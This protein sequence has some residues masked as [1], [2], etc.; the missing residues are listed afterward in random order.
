MTGSAKSKTNLQITAV[1][2]SAIFIFAFWLVSPTAQIFGQTPVATP[3]PVARPRPPY[4]PRNRRVPRQTPPTNGGELP[5]EKSFDVDPKVN[6]TLCVLSGDVK[7]NGWDR[8][9]IRALVEDGNEVSFSAREK[10]AQTGRPNLVKI[11]GTGNAPIEAGDCLSGSEIELD[12]PRGATVNLTG[13]ENDISVAS[14]NKAT[15]RNDGGDI[16]LS[17]IAQGIEARTYEGDITVGKSGGMMRLTN[18]NGNIIVYETRSSDVGDALT[19]RTSSGSVMIQ[20]SSQK[21]ISAV[22]NTGSIRF[23]G[24]FESGGQYS[25]GTTNGTIN[26]EIPADS[27]CRIEAFYGGRFQSDIPLKEITNDVAPSVKKIV[28]VIGTGDASLSLKNISGSIYIR[29]K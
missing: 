11:S 20:Q 17:D 25:F 3:A 8:S 18:T 15:I 29:K 27:S 19:A 28:S 21:Q 14:I 26:L 4:I 23:N 6:I 10:N 9:E 16:S 13:R 2:K 1:L 24:K 7:I 5:L 22:S 12:V